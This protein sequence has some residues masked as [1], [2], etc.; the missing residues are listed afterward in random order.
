MSL[1]KSA[2]NRNLKKVKKN[3]TRFQSTQLYGLFLS[4][5][6]ILLVFVQILGQKNYSSNPGGA[7]KADQK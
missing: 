4:Q 6:N 2:S 1:K 5:I 3:K 7:L